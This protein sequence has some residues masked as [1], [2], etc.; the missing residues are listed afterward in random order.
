M[1]EDLDVHDVVLASDCE[2]VVNDINWGTNGPNA[3]ITHEI[4]ASSSGFSTCKFIFEGRNFNLEPQNVAMYS[5]N[6]GIGRNVWLDN[7]HN[8]TIVPMN[9]SLNQ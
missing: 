9:M 2:G 3:A 6:L 7:P 5:Y 8:P 4:I 1:A